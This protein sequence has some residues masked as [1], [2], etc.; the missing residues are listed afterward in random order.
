M[1]SNFYAKHKAF[2]S[3]FLASVVMGGFLVFYISSNMVAL[4]NY[5]P[6]WKKDFNETL[7]LVIKYYDISDHHLTT[8]TSSSSLLKDK[9]FLKQIQKEALG[10]M[11]DYKILNMELEEINPNWRELARIK[12]D[13]ATLKI[14]EQEKFEE[15]VRTLYGMSFY[16]FE[17]KVLMPQSQFEIVVE[18]LKKQNKNYDEWLKSKKK[19]LSISI[20]VDGLEWREGEVAIK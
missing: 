1:I 15:G 13:N 12:I 6:I 18:E 8:D 16:E 14:K 3:I 20:M 4:I 9:Y 19:K 7:D 5:D 10:R 11:I 2:L 17:R